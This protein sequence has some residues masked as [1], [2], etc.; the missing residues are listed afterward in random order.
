MDDG[1]E[2][3]QPSIAVCC[4][5]A[6]W[7]GLCA[8]PGNS[9]SFPSAHLIQSCLH[10]GALVSLFIIRRNTLCG[11][12]KS[13]LILS[14]GESE[15]RLGFFRRQW[16]L[17]WDVT[18]RAWSFAHS[19]RELKCKGKDDNSFKCLAN[20]SLHDN[21]QRG[22]VD[23]DCRWKISKKHKSVW[24]IT[25][26]H[27][28][29]CTNCL[30]YYWEEEWGAIRNL[31]AAPES[32]A[33]PSVQA[34]NRDQIDAVVK[35][36]MWTRE[37]QAR[38]KRSHVEFHWSGKWVFESEGASDTRDRKPGSNKSA[39]QYRWPGFLPL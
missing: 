30:L 4:A 22:V 9:L 1:Y 37:R 32:K 3:A 11:L 36:S 2:L 31:M 33:L 34:K 13:L 14:R 18:S 23:I 26:S 7:A 17:N 27:L 10:W 20:K 24:Q 8:M 12:T 38:I 25:S 21:V 5:W 15:V 19:L 28:A 16:P 35:F 29:I 39:W 6:M